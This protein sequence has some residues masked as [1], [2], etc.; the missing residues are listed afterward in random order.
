MLDVINQ[1]SAEAV[2]EAMIQE[3]FAGKIALVSSFG[4]ESAILLH[5]IA[6]NRQGDAGDLPRYR[7]AVPRDAGLSR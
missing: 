6:R 1:S 2:L 5:M 4:T 3:R 7:Q